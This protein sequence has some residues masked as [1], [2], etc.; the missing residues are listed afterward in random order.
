MP[1]IVLQKVAVGVVVYEVLVY[2][3]PVGGTEQIAHLFVAPGAVPANSRSVVQRQPFADTGCEHRVELQVADPLHPVF[4]RVD[5]L[6]A[7][8]AVLGI[9]LVPI[10]L[11]VARIARPPCLLGFAVARIARQITVVVG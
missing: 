10:D 3:R 4:E 8:H 5:S 7:L 9:K 1:Q 6:A 2:I 11:R